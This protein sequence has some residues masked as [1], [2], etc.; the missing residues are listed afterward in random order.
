MIGLGGD[1]ARHRFDL[2][3]RVCCWAETHAIEGVPTD[4]RRTKMLR[5][6]PLLPLQAL[7]RSPRFASCSGLG[8]TSARTV[9]ELAVLQTAPFW[10]TKSPRPLLRVRA[11]VSAGPLRV[12]LAID[13]PVRTRQFSFARLSLAA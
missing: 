8:L 13:C 4:E 11:P 10:L 6:L 9:H 12:F 1:E 2:C 5:P 3:A 7:V